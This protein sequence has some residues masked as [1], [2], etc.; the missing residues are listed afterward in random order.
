MTNWGDRTLAVSEDLRAYLLE[1]Y[2]IS[3]D[4][5]SLTVNGVDTDR[6]SPEVDGSLLRTTLSADGRAVILH[7]SRLDREVSTLAERLMEAMRSLAEQATLV[8]VGDGGHRSALELKARALRREL[9]R[10]AIV[11]LGA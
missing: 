5:I 2:D 3:P 10:E 11:F 9:G 8:I 1:N 7:V 6:F 4:R